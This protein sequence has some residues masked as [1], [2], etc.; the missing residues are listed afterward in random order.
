VA[1][2][3]GFECI[4]ADDVPG[5]GEDLRAKIHAATD[6]AALVLADVSEPRPNIYYEVGYAVARGKPL[7]LLAHR[8]AEIHTDLLGVEMIHYETG[9]K[10][11][12]EE[13]DRA[14]RHALRPHVASHLSLL[15]AMVIPPKPIPSYI[16]ANPKHPVKTSRMRDHPEERR[17][18]GDYLGVVGVL[19]AFASAYGDSV[20]P[21]L[22]SE[23]YTPADL[24]DWDANLFLI[25]SPKVNRRTGEFLADIQQG[26]PPRWKFRRCPGEEQV[27]DY[28]AQLV[29][30]LNGKEFET[31][32]APSTD[33]KTS[34]ARDGE[35]DRLTDWGLVVRGP[36]PRHPE[37]V[38]TI[39]AGPHSLGTGA[40]CLAA[41][42]PQ[43][44]DEI[45]Q[46][47]GGVAALANTRASFWVLV[48]GTES[49]DR[50]LDVGGVEIVD[51][52][53]Y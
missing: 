43:R 27:K 51:A 18:F 11:G 40:A 49:E 47:L 22:I 23:D 5:A 7:L 16:L 14:L 28:R 29:G 20:T 17:T 39:M 35:V 15:R 46:R 12:F 8:G 19:N 25:G 50:H 31:D 38:V 37:R 32:C 2:E 41:T 42:K 21:E 52:G 24:S 26:R 30:E 9:Q 33:A 6:N 1:E 4:R 45:A 53:V 13:F 3:T 34:G 44:I 36:H 48:K 10:G